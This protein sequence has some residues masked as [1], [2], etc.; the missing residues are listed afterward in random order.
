MIGNP[1]TVTFGLYDL[2]EHR[3]GTSLGQLFGERFEMIVA[4][5]AAGFRGIHTTEHH[6]NPVDATP[7]PNLFLAAAA[8]HTERIRLG[9]IVNV[10]PMYDPVRLAEEIVMLD[11][12]CD[13]RLDVGVGKGVSPVELRL[14]GRDPHV[15][16]ERF[17]DELAV[18]LGY[19]SAAEI[20]GAPMPAVTVQRP[21]PPLWY[22]GNASYAGRRNLNVV[23]GGGIEQIAVKANEH[24]SLISNPPAP[25]DQLNPGRPPVIAVSRHVLVGA[26]AEAA[27]QRAELAWRQYHDNVR[28]HFRRTGTQPASN[29]TFDGDAASA[30]ASGALLAGTPDEIAAALSEVVVATG[31]TYLLISFCWGDLEHREAMESL[32]LFIDEVIPQVGPN[33]I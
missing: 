13:G 21:Y 23:L 20:E 3:S 22:A 15:A 9:T 24:R 8:Q 29:P 17:D 11:H 5:E 4:A 16:H 33:R 18:L 10:V 27:G 19:L 31:V 26:S 25:D 1:A 30:A 6:L 7:S 14:M 2:I 12:L 28:A 32:R